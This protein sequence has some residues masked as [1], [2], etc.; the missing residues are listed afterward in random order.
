[1]KKWVKYFIYLFIGIALVVV[2]TGLFT[3]RSVEQTLSQMPELKS[4]EFA[5]FPDY[6]KKHSDQDIF[7]IFAHADD[8]LTVLGAVA[9]IKE[10]HPDAPIH[11]LIVSDNGKGKI[12]PGTCY[13]Q[14]ASDCRYQE[15]VQVS[16]CMG[17]AEPIRMN[18]KDGGLAQA[19]NLKQKI[20]KEIEN[21]AGTRGIAAV[22]THDPPGLYGHPD[23]VA[24]SDAV[25][26][27]FQN[28]KI[29]IVSVALTEYFKKVIPRIPPG[30]Q[31]PFPPITHAYTLSDSDR[32]KIICAS[33]SYPSQKQVLFALQL[34]LSAEK[35]WT[36]LSKNFLSIQ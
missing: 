8:E 1:M 33:K 31:R 16:K 27:I 36:L 35:F 17:I 4:E 24:V 13:R 14:T 15:A 21:T 30:N 11:W 22:F 34:G 28:K 29:P 3:E 10:L 25:R 18:F 32:R 7:L 5:E 2:V 9:H 6:L 19:E 23:H 26:E 12:F 20:L